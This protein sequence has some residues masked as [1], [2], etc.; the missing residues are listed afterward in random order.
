M[1]V[2]LSGTRFGASVLQTFKIQK[3]LGTIIEQTV[4]QMEIG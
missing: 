2:E 3:Y 4:K 1:V